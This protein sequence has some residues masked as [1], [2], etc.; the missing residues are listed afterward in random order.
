MAREEIGLKANAF[1]CAFVLFFFGF[2]RLGR[3]SAFLYLNYWMPICDESCKLP[4]DEISNNFL[5]KADNVIQYFCDCRQ[6]P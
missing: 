4:R 6:N 1:S 5:F 2:E 3:N